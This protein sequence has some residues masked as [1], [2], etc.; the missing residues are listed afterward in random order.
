MP[1]S[2]VLVPIVA[3]SE[4]F[5]ASGV[6]LEVACV[7]ASAEDSAAQLPA[8]TSLVKTCTLTTRV[9]TKLLLQQVMAAALELELLLDILD[10][11]PSLVSRLWSATS[12]LHAFKS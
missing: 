9:L 7:A 6:G 11:R 12:V 8:G 1:V 3:V 5:V 2:Q 4:A 10:L